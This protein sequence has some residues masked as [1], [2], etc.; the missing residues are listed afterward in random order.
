MKIKLEKLKDKH[1]LVL[2][3]LLIVPAILPLLRR[4]FFHFSDEPSLSIVYQMFKAIISGQIPPRWAPDMSFEYGYPLFNFYYVLPF[5]LGSVFY[6]LTSSL[7]WSVKGV[8]FTSVVLS[9]LFMYAWMR[10]HTGKLLSLVGAII[11]I[12]TPYRAVDLYVRGAIG[13]LLSFAFFPLIALFV[14]KTMH[15][16]SLKYVSLLA[17]STGLFLLNHN[18]APMFFLP[19]IFAYGVIIG[20]SKNS[21]KSIFRM[22]LGM[23]L[24]FGLSGYFWI[25]AFLE[26][27]LL[28]DQTPYNYIDHFPFIKQLIIPYWGYG[29]SVWGPSDQISF[30]IGLANLLL[31]I[32]SLFFVFRSR[33]S[34]KRIIKPAFFVI[35]FLVFVFLMNIRSRFLWEISGFSKYIQFPWRLLMLT[36]FITSSLVMFIP[37]KTAKIKIIAVILILFSIFSTFNYFKP[38]EY[39]ESS[40][41]YFLRRMFARETGEVSEEY[42][43][44]S[45]DFLL[46]PVWNDEKPSKLPK[47][48][49]TSDDLNIISIDEITD[50]N[51][52]VSVESEN[53][54]TLYFHSYY[55][56]GWQTKIDGIIV[57]PEISSPHGNIKL[58]IDKGVHKI[59][60]NW[61]E[62]PLR[63]VANT[64]SFASLGAI[65]FLYIS[66]KRRKNL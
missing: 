61:V 6:A 64:I 4:D 39:Y 66:R 35:S 65:L 26:K 32:I 45:E 12:Y 52:A 41:E 50:V 29:A 59:S 53:G 49:F 54:G 9:V 62:T 2:L 27:G 36:T 17:I 13:E 51:Y 24:G 60:V 21:F 16:K 15:D 46:L 18:L 44:Y 23:G 1:Y 22:V 34:L 33:N 43:S 30:Q 28:Y 5:Y 47:A 42:E 63:K 55:F 8:F 20:L 48:K 11:Y 57:L 14:Y 58:Y 19:W 56:P 25:P 38:S 40:D 37:E 10:Q 31:V 7:I 3:L